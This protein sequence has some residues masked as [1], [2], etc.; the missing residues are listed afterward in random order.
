M[1]LDTNPP[2][3]SPSTENVEN[4]T[5]PAVIC[6]N[7]QPVCEKLIFLCGQC[8]NGFGSL[9]ACKQHMMQV[10]NSDVEY[11][12][13]KWHFILAVCISMKKDKLFSFII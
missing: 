11:I 5:D 13:Q 1:K 3:S 6:S 9:E 10:I 4:S 2:N 12:L 8:N 7:P